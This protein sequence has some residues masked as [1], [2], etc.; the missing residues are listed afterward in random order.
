M[1]NYTLMQTIARANRVLARKNNGIFR[2]LHGLW[3]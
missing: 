3:K 1:R 2:D